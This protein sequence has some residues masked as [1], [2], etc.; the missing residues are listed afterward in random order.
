MLTK[1]IRN[2]GLLTKKRNLKA[3]K[4]WSKGNKRR[5]GSRNK[6]NKRKKRDKDLKKIF[7]NILYTR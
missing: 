3:E 2:V 1:E 6:I 7:W 5:K 4:K